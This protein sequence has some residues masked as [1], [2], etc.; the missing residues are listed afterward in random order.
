MQTKTEPFHDQPMPASGTVE[1][2]PVRFIRLPE[3]LAITGMSRSQAYRL[4]ALGQFPRHVKLGAAMSAWIEAEVMQWCAD[5]IATRE[6]T[7]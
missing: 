5:R 4:E 1:V 6:V 3:V 7:A 2:K